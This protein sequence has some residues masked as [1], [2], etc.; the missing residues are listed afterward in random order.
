MP[1]STSLQ[2]TLEDDKLMLHHLLKRTGNDQKGGKVF[3]G[4]VAKAQFAV[5]RLFPR[6]EPQ[7]HNLQ[8]HLL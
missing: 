1:V 8:G 3:K 7:Q 4:G 6:R 5:P 2:V